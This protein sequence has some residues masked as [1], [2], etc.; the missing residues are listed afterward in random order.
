MSPHSARGRN[1]T[2]INIYDTEITSNTTTHTAT[3]RPLPG[4]PATWTV[5][6]LLGRVLTRNEAI[7]AMTIAE[8]TATP[9]DPRNAAEDRRLNLESWAAELG[10]SAD[11]VT[12]MSSEP[13]A[14]MR[15]Q[16]HRAAAPAP[17]RTNVLGNP[18]P[19][20]CTTNHV[21]QDHTINL[22]ISDPIAS[23]T[24]ERARVRFTQD[25]SD[26]Y[27]RAHPQVS[28]VKGTAVLQLS[29]AQSE[30][31]ADLLRELADGCTPDVLRELADEVDT[32]ADFIDPMRKYATPA[33]EI[34]TDHEAEP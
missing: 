21:T 10:L 34:S 7:T 31:L 32:A 15:P 18:C 1:N 23:K 9:A 6:W 25:G 8:T 20:W 30:G 19:D 29:H 5:T 11:E 26:R 4:Q 14:G 22:H 27:R 33:D 24:L 2:S 28:V 17:E 16:A 13:P 12:E 3:A